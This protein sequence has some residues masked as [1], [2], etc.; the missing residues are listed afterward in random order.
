MKKQTPPSTDLFTRLCYS[1]LHTECLKEYRF[2]SKRMWRF[3]YALPQYKIAV[4]IDGGV[5]TRG[6]HVRPKGYLGDLEKFNEAAALGWVVLKF[7]PQQQYNI[8]TLAILQR[9]IKQR[10]YERNME[11]CKGE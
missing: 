11:T 10:I 4:E 6:R 9:T 5:W 8:R 2:H 1:E 3:D 7:T